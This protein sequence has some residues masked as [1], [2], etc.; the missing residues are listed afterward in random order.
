[1][2]Q[3]GGNLNTLKSND[4]NPRLVFHYGIPT[5]AV[6]LAYDSV[7]KILAISTKDGRIKLLG[8]DN[9][10]ALLESNDTVPSKFLQFLEN[11]GI[12][13]NVTVWDIERKQLSHVQIFKQEITSFMVIQ[14]SFYMYVGDSLGNVSTWKLDQEKHH[15]VQMRY[16]IPLSA[17]HGNTTEVAGDTA[18]MYLL[19]QPM[20]ESKRVLLIFRDGF[21][22]LWGIEESKVIF[23]TGGNMLHSLAHETKKVTSACW[24]CPFGS[25]VVVGYG[26]GEILLWSIPSLSNPRSASAINKEDLSAT[27]NVPICKL[28]LGYKMDKIPIFSLK[29]VYGDG[30]ASRLYVNGESGSSSSNLFQ[31]IL[32]NEQTESRMIKLALPLSEPCLDMQIIS[33]T[34]D[35]IKH[36]QDSLLLLLKSGHLCAY[37]DSL[38]EKYL[39]QCQTRSPPS[40]PKQVIVK[41]PF[42][43]SSITAA[44]FITND[45]NPLSAMDE[46]YKLLAKS[47]PPILPTE[48]KGKDGSHLSSQFG[49]FTKAKSLYITGHSDGTINFW[50]LS[51]PIFLPISSVKQQSEDDHS[52]SGIP[53]TA[54]YIDISSRLLVSGDQSGMVSI[55]MMKYP[56]DVEIDNFAG[57]TKKGSIIHGVKLIKVN[58]AV[59]SFNVNHCSG[60]LAVGSD[61]G[62]VSVIDMEGPTIL[63][64]KQFTSEL[65]T[66]V[67]S[68]QFETCSFHGFEKNVL[69]VAAKDSSIV[70]LDSDTGSTLSANAVGPKKPYKTLFMQILGNYGSQLS[71]L[72]MALYADVSDDLVLLCNEKAVYVYSLIHVVQGI[73]KVLYKKKFHGTSCCWAS[74]IYNHNSDIALVL[75]FASGKI[76]IRSL[77]ELSLL[78]ETSI[79]G[80]TLSNSKLNSS[81]DGSICASSGA[82]LVLVKGDQ[83]VFF[84]SLLLQK[85]IYR[86]LDHISLV[87]KESVTVIQEVPV[88]GSIIHKEKKKGIFS[89]VIKGSKAKP[90]AD[91]T[92]EESRVSIGDELST[93]FSTENFPLDVENRDHVVVNSDEVELSI[94]DID[95][96]DTVQ[97]PKGHNMI[98]ALNKQLTS[99]FQAIK[100]KL[101]QK[102]VKNEKTSPKKENEDEKNGTVDEIKKRYGF[103]SSGG[104][105]EAKMAENKLHENLRKL[106]GIN[107]RTT[108]MEDT[109]KSFSALAKEVLRTA[110]QDKRS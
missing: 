65:C 103:P 39:L 97:K 42:A 94:D 61:Q 88:S 31:I 100:G 90:E 15:L 82:D 26:N 108:E 45:S 92:A 37:D 17:S 16:N 46:D 52:V 43:D 79:R 83:E 51:C 10:Q 76:E 106:Q 62:Y 33:S 73:K 40:L 101:K 21:I 74:T 64:Q 50:D 25:K 72:V 87:Y 41:L 48:T 78:K 102:M 29:W 23:I 34:S 89:S 8:K 93:I 105:S 86:L 58:G 20:A 30:K 80:L 96:E 99:K 5:G 69:L 3:P 22:V 18:V 27:Q 66:G 95:L 110:E 47:S 84:V 11:Q 75:L 49:G 98:P 24:A 35:Q 70:V 60:H 14:H 36:K 67:I 55:N 59:L 32:L 2:Q 1:M 57:N 44:K 68:M 53:V 85:E 77:P 71:L 109:A 13:F 7:Q 28:N 91:T 56:C 12:L 104:S 9:T 4:V 107:M 63:S 6:Q 19:P 38:I 54:L 81:S